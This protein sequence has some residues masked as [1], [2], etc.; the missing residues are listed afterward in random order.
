MFSLN[1]NIFR[2]PSLTLTPKSIQRPTSTPA[3]PISIP[4]PRHNL[5]SKK[6]LEEETKR[7][8][9]SM[10][11]IPSKKHYVPVIPLTIYQ[12]WYTKDLPPN[13]QKNVEYLKQQNPEFSYE[14]YDDNA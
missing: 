3:L 12:T 8:L 1:G 11:Y 9:Y 2:K 4:T 10:P 14:L 5:L 7:K 6:D 13:M